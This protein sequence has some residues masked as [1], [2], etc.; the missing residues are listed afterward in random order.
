MEV[1]DR[2]EETC[3]LEVMILVDTSASMHDKLLTVK[4]AL[5]DLSI[6]M[7]AR[8][9]ENLFSIYQFPAKNEPISQIH[10]WSSKLDSISVIFPKLISGGLTPTG[11]AI[12]AALRRWDIPHWK[13]SYRHAEEG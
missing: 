9:G 4:E 3:D 13:G 11:T 5:I 1:V 8:S 6:N 12:E 7:H 10:D 2:I